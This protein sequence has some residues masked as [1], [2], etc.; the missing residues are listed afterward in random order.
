MLY[1]IIPPILIVVSL[2]GIIVFLVKKAPEVANLEKEES[3]A[4]GGMISAK[5]SIWSIL[6]KKNIEEHKD[7]KHKTLLF[8]E[9]TTKKMKVFFLK[10]ENMFT[11]WGES[12]RNKR[13]AREEEH[14]V[15]ALELIKEN[16]F[17]KEAE[18]N[19][20]P[21]NIKEEEKEEVKIEKK[22]ILEKILVERI[23]TNPKDI[24]AYERLGEYYFEI[25]NWNYAKECY[26][27]VLKLNPRNIGIRSKMR[28]LERMLSK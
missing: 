25:E 24:E 26:K 23:A 7:F 18:N 15:R 27:Q 4:Q 3:P 21:E 12:I 8:L 14:V 13:K 17:S 6:R 20:V 28:K 10:M 11:N 19:D 5:K 22:D 2:V 1:T 16:K 9:K